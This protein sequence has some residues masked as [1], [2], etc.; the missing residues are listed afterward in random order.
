MVILP[1]FSHL[2]KVSIETPRVLAARPIFIKEESILVLARP[3]SLRSGVSGRREGVLAATATPSR[4]S[5]GVTL[6][7]TWKVDVSLEAETALKEAAFLA[8]TLTPG[9]GTWSLLASTPGVVPRL[10]NLEYS[11]LVDFDRV[12]LGLDQLK[13]LLGEEFLAEAARDKN[14]FFFL[15]DGLPINIWRPV[16]PKIYAFLLCCIDSVSIVHTFT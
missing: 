5:L 2:L 9:V 6:G 4:C 13:I 10:F 12:K 16:L 15:V 1:L 8:V 7:F 11:D 14:N 3:P